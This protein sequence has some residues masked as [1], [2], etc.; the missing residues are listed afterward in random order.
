MSAATMK[1]V[2]IHQK[3]K[4]ELS[5]DPAVPLLGIRLKESKSMYNKVTCIPMCIAAL[6]TIA[7]LWN[8]PKCPSTD[9]WIEKMC[10]VYIYTM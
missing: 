7:K 3:S 2:E 9:E 5:Y 8:Q 10:I 4:I 1:I 6:F